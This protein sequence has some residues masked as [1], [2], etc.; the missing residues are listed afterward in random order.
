MADIIPVAVDTLEACRG[1][2]VFLEAV[3]WG[4]DR[5]DRMAHETTLVIRCVGNIE[6][7]TVLAVEYFRPVADRRDHRPLGVIRIG[8]VINIPGSVQTRR[9]P[10]DLAKTRG[11][12]GGPAEIVTQHLFGPFTVAL[13]P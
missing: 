2:D 9:H 8:P 12:G 3:F 7:H 5:I 6:K 11:G 1:M 13:H 4:V 10:P